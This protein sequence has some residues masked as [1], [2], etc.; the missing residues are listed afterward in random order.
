MLHNFI[1]ERRDEITGRAGVLARARDSHHRFAD[2]TG[3]VS[4]FLTQVSTSLRD[5]PTFS[6]QNLAQITATAAARAP[7]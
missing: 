5:G 2:P 7:R 1:A 6:A 3:E 4:E